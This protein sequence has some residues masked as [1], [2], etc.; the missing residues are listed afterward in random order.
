MGVFGDLKH[1]RWKHKVFLEPQF[2]PTIAVP[3]SFAIS[4]SLWF[5]FIDD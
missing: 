4:Q 5:F 2:I 3:I 1:R